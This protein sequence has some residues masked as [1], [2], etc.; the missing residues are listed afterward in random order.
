MFRIIS[1]RIFSPCSFVINNTD[2]RVENWV[3]IK[4][5]IRNIDTICK[6]KFIYFY[7]SIIYTSE[8]LR[9]HYIA[10]ILSLARWITI[11]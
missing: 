3:S 2:S 4:S 11:N 8:I 1:L 7:S 10:I 6:V 9:T 5:S